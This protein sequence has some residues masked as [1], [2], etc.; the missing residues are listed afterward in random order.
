[1]AKY[2]AMPLWTDAYLADTQHLTL[3]EHGAYLKL[4]MIMWRSP[5]CRL[6][7]DKQK[8]SKMLAIA[9][10]RFNKIWHIVGDFFYESNGFLYQKKLSAVYET[11]NKV[12]EQRRRAG[13][14]GAQAKALKNK[15]TRQ[16]NG[17]AKRKLSL[18]KTAAKRK[19]TVKQNGSNQNQNLTEKGGLTPSPKE[20]DDNANLPLPD[21]NGSAQ[22]EGTDHAT[23]RRG[24]KLASDWRPDADQI[25]YAIE[26]GYSR[27]EAE[28]IAD[29][30]VNYFTNGK[31]KNQAHINWDRTWQTWISTELRTRP[32]AGKRVKRDSPHS[33]MLAGAL[34]S[35][36][37]GPE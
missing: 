27:D 3:E 31:G 26:K 33:A 28:S 34:T 13:M 23:Q 17:Q 9:D 24:T 35:D 6:A 30:F 11:L 12:S 8:L 36:N 5:G 14:K 1:M 7:N 16:A 19:Q 21:P 25:G 22:P 2:P 10:R 29:Q 37:G 15:K 4:L 20:N 18:S 32:P